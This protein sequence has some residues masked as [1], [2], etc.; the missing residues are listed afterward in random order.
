M[1]TAPFISWHRLWRRDVDLAL[2]EII[3][4]NIS[5]HRNANYSGATTSTAPV[6]APLA[7]LL[8]TCQ[9]AFARTKHRPFVRVPT[10]CQ[11]LESRIR[12]AVHAELPGTAR[13][14]AGS[15][16]ARQAVGAATSCTGGAQA[17]GGGR[18]PLRKPLSQP[19]LSVVGQRSISCV[20]RVGCAPSAAARRAIRACC[21]TRCGASRVRTT[22][23]RGT[24][25]AARG[26]SM[27]LWAQGP[28]RTGWFSM[29]GIAR[30]CPKRLGSLPSTQGSASGSVA[31]V[32]TT[33]GLNPVI[34]HRT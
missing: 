16:S 33:T 14:L 31:G 2:D 7:L 18:K 34:T 28:A 10:G 11:S 3:V 22:A 1:L 25:V 12:P 27:S 24:P 29:R 6:S 30:V 32:A 15:D 13:R 19:P 26:T 8:A 9:A 17:V 20:T 4:G 23:H 5:S 21:A